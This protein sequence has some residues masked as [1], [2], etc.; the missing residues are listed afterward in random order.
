M[1]RQKIRIGDILAEKGF[2]TEAQLLDALKLQKESNF[3]RKLGQIFVDDGLI[4]QRAFTEL[5]A[6]Q[7]KIDF[8]DL[9]GTE[10]DFTLMSSFQ[11]SMLKNAD[12]IPFKEDAEYIH[13]AV[14]DPLNYEG[15]ELLEPK[16]CNQAYQTVR[17]ITQ[18]YSACLWPFGYHL[19]Y[20]EYRYQY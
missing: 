10:V 14:S 11:N 9:F 5:L 19:R 12:A 13:V 3:T 6:N 1:I 15:I 17:G 7:L 4:S 8:I 16:Y 18:R 2:I 20:K